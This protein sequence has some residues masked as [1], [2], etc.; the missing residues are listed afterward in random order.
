MVKDLLH[1]SLT[2]PSFYQISQKIYTKNWETI[3]HTLFLEQ[4]I[5]MSSAEINMATIEEEVDIESLYQSIS[6]Q[7]PQAPSIAEW[8]VPIFD[9]AKSMIHLLQ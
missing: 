8:L 5:N 2:H 4:P 9:H 7:A 3:T 6:P 1:T